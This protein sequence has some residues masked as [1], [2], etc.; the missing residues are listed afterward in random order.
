MY[1][2]HAIVDAHGRLVAGRPPLPL[3]PAS[4]L[5]SSTPVCVVPRRLRVPAG[6]LTLPPTRKILMRRALMPVYLINDFRSLPQIAPFRRGLRRRLPGNEAA[7]PPTH[8][9]PRL[10]RT[11][12]PSTR[13]HA[14]ACAFHRARFRT[15]DKMKGV[16]AQLTRTHTHTHTHTRTHTHTHTETHTHTNMKGD[17]ARL[18]KRAFTQ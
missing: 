14:C 8:A 11:S 7:A 2:T 17:M 5:R 18:T 1:N 6:R 10:A 13:C 16:F 9:P 4:L 15:R 3:A 12:R